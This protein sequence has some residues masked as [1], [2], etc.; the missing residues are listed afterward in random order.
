AG[1]GYVDM[2]EQALPDIATRYDVRVLARRRPSGLPIRT[3]DDYI[4]ALRYHHRRKAGTKAA[5]DPLAED[6][7]ATFALIEPGA[8]VDPASR[9]HDSV[10]LKD[11]VVEAGAVLVRSVVCPGGFLRR[12]KTAVETFVRAATYTHRTHRGRGS[13]VAVSPNKKV[14]PAPAPASAAAG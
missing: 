6:W 7:K 4:Q 8:Q 2:K 1:A 13:P 14:S 10:V 11:A 9:V 12:D 3:L 5:V